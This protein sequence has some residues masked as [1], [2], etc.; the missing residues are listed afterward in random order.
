MY[1]YEIVQRRRKPRIDLPIP[2]TLRGSDTSGKPFDIE[3][4]LDNLSVGGFHVRLERRL[5][6]AT[7]LFALIRIAGMEI[8]ATGVVRWV[9]SKPDGSFGHGVAFEGYRILP[10][11]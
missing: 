1:P 3:A 8:E 10:E 7:S 6:L 4:A 11:T 5:E 9:K 2:A